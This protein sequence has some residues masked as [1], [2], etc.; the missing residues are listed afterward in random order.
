MTDRLL[1]LCFLFCSDLLAFILNKTCQLPYILLALLHHVFFTGMIF[2]FLR[3]KPEEKIL[4]ASALI[5]AA[6]LT[7]SFCESFLSC[8]FLLCLHI[9]R[10]IPVPF[11]GK[12][13]MLLITC[14]QLI[15]KILSIY[16]MSGH[17]KTESFKETG[18]WHILL[19]V[20]LLSVTLIIDA[21]NWSASYGILRSRADLSLYYEQLFNHAEMSVITALS[22]FA[23]G[24][25]LFGTEKIWLEQ[26]KNSQ[27]H[28]QITA[29]RMLEE[30]YRQLERLRHDMK[31]H[32]I[33]LSNLLE[34]QE[35]EQ[36]K[37]YLENMEQGGSLGACE[38]ITGNRTADA[39]LYQK[40][41]LALQKEIA[42][43]CDVQIP[44]ACG[45]HE[46]DLCVLLGN[47]LDNALE[48][49]EKL[50]SGSDRF[51]TVQSRMVKKCFFLE[52]KNSTDLQNKNVFP[53][54]GKRHSGTHGIGLLNIQ[55][56]VRRYQGTI[57]AEIHDGVF[58]ISILLPVNTTV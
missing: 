27:Y 40:R 15:V 8:L 55:D 5:A 35:L 33:A 31:N 36:A 11:L 51:I 39:L 24:F 14:I 54:S 46:F 22:L 45:I 25:C 9:I 48:A 58:V 17:L 32:I 56:T 1:F 44:P 57:D 53:P 23:A 10:N 43:E 49:C 37:D 3:K 42:W 29:Y 26:Q 12:W 7:S 21:A 18:R 52:V 28:A 50:P 41:N 2:L 6:T 4:T 20:P 38:E 34:H 16:W 47:I 19:S 13:E 30:Q